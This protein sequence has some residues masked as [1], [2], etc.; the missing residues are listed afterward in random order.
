MAS[1]GLGSAWADRWPDPHAALVESG[2]NYTLEGDP[3]ALQ[4]EDLRPLVK[5]FVDA[6]DEFIPLLR[7]AFP[8]MGVWSRAIYTL[9]NDPTEME[10]PP[11][12]EIR[13]LSAEDAPALENLSEES[14]W[15]SKTWGG[16]A[17][18]A[19]S[20]RSWG[21]FVSEDGRQLLASVA[22]TFFTGRYYEDLGLVTEAGYRER[23]L[24]TA[25]TLALCRAV[26]AAG[27]TPTWTTSTDNR[28]SLSVA[29]RLGFTPLKLDRLFVIGIPIPPAP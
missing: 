28:P 27:R 6:P 23:G 3:A 16:P 12:A 2:G 9:D 25:C 17:G 20:G 14:A 1:T 19:A 26:R 8:R 11:K 10:R 15:I 4:P 5:G 21:A 29:I 13:Q 22:C 7:A 18:L 24:G